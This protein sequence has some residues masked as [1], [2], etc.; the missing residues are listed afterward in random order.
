VK[1]RPETIS[2]TTHLHYSNGIFRAP[3]CRNRKNPAARLDGFWTLISRESREPIPPLDCNPGSK[4]EGMLVYRSE[5]AAMSAC[6]HQKRLYGVICAPKR[7]SDL[8]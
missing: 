8:D 1:K 5:R 3:S 2:S 6:R 4:D 7:L